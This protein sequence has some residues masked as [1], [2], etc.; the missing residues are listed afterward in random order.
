[1]TSVT[2][3]FATASGRA[4][5]RNVVASSIINFL[6]RRE[7]NALIQAFPDQAWRD[8]HPGRLIRCCDQRNIERLQWFYEYNH[9]TPFAWPQRTYKKQFGT[10][11]QASNLFD[12]AMNSFDEEVVMIAIKV[13]PFN[14]E[15]TAHIIRQ[16]LS[17]KTWT[18]AADM[19]VEKEPEAIEIL[20]QHG[21]A[22]SCFMHATP[23]MLTWFAGKGLDLN[24]KCEL[25]NQP[26]LSYFVEFAY[27]E[28]VEAML[29]AG[30]KVTSYMIELAGR[31]GEEAEYEDPESS[32][33]ENFYDIE[34]ML[35]AALQKQGK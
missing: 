32:Y 19:L 7:I 6:N 16:H 34:S 29:S 23:T 35:K 27:K 28:H 17:K 20:K 1:M 14:A 31:K 3:S 11:Y 12:A 26:V 8:P 5:F 18:R 25:W 4:V 30:A 9:R 24:E 10:L 21:N 13:M 2:D 33:Y 15:D 22:Y